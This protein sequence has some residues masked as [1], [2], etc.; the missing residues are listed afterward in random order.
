MPATQAVGVYQVTVQ[1]RTNVTVAQ[2]A[3]RTIT[4]QIGNLR[5]TGVT[6]TPSLAS[7]QL[8]GTPVSFTAAGQG[9]SG[10]YQYEFWYNAGAGQVRGRA[11][12]TD[13]VWAMPTTLAAG[14]YTI[15]V[16][17]KTNTSTTEDA[18]STATYVLQ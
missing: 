15:T 10:P 16:L 17:V 5:A 8:R 3:S 6:L 13:P 4:Y 2:D 7:P 12:G 11:Y 1:V 18:R 14:T 9:G